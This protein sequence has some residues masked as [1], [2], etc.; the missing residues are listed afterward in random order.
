[1]FVVVCVC[2]CIATFMTVCAFMTMCTYASYMYYF[3][4]K[5]FKL[6]Y[7]AR[8]TYLTGVSE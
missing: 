5:I 2:M 3:N 8:V 6:I 7:E 4:K 1:M